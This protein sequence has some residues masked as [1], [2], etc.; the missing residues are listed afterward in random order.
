LL[1]RVPAED[2]ALRTEYAY[3]LGMALLS[4]EPY[5]G[6]VKELAGILDSLE[7]QKKNGVMKKVYDLA[8]SL[9]DGGKP[10]QAY[11]M[12]AALHSARPTW[13]GR[14]WSAKFQALHKRLFAALLSQ[15]LKGLASED[16]KARAEAVVT[17]RSLGKPALPA[18]LDALEEAATE[19]KKKFEERL[20]DFLKAEH[21]KAYDPALPLEKKKET[22]Q[23]WRKA[24][25][26]KPPEKPAA[27][28]T[29][30][31]TRE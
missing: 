18:L 16:D 28:K 25:A 1:A 24:L 31:E 8:E 4:A 27:A 14:E 29:G 23:E 22:I 7:P 26:T 20:L 13:D 2:K 11:N 15:S 10:R 30:D 9:S 3:E 5:T 12:L 21:A 19:S 17:L 6:G